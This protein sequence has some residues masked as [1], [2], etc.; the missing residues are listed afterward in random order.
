MDGVFGLCDDLGHVLGKREMLYGCK[1]E[2]LKR[3]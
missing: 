1:N 2:N 3:L